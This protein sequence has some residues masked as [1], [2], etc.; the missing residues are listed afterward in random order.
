MI[1]AEM[2]ILSYHSIKEEPGARY[3][4]AAQDLE[5]LLDDCQ[6]RNVRVIPLS[7]LESPTV[8]H[9]SSIMLTFDDGYRDNYTTLFPM[10]E[11]RRVPAVIFLVAGRVGGTNNW[12]VD[13]ELAGEPLLDWEHI[14]EMSAAGVLFGSHG[15]THADLCTTDE[16]GLEFEI[17]ESKQVL[18]DRLGKPVEAFAYP[19]GR[20]DERVLSAVED[21]GYR[22]AM[23]AGSGRVKARSKLRLA[24]P[25]VVIRADEPS[26]KTQARIRGWWKPKDF[27]GAATE[28]VGKAISTRLGSWRA[29]R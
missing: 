12:D 26:W 15:M 21:A 7:A 29:R 25:R 22:Y 1:A 11:A 20:F 4:T 19:F 23:I 6:R 24:M 27:Y 2:R 18:E 14:E 16:A 8:W 17:H 5:D 3:I 28:I 9:R 13:G 10:I